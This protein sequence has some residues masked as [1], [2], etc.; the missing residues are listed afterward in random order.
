VLRGFVS[1]GEHSDELKNICFYKRLS[2]LDIIYSMKLS[3][4]PCNNRHNFGN[5]KRGLSF[6]RLWVWWSADSRSFI[7]VSEESATVVFCPEDG[8]GR[9]F[10]ARC[11]VV[12]ASIKFSII[13]SRA[14][15]VLKYILKLN[16]ELYSKV[17]QISYTLF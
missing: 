6:L 8:G 7:D 10:R 14:R 17:S 11:N 12:Q 3:P 1:V 5:N 16:T 2:S 15:F 13:H 4:F 9:F